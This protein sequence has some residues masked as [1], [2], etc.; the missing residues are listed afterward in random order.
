MFIAVLSVVIPQP[1]RL[2]AH[3]QGCDHTK[4]VPSTSGGSE[5]LTIIW[6]LA[7]AKRESEGEGTETQTV[8]RGKGGCSQIEACV[9]KYKAS[10]MQRCQ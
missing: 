10:D 4:L 2:C 8:S 9:L 1:P 6:H 7:A 5:T 3:S